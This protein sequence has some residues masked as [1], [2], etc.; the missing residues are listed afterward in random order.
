M[1]RGHRIDSDLS[2]T[3]SGVPDRFANRPSG[4]RYWFSRFRTNRWCPN[5]ITPLS[6]CQ[7]PFLPFS[8]APV[9]SQTKPSLFRSQIF[10]NKLNNHSAQAV[11]LAHKP[12]LALS[13]PGLP[14]ATAHWWRPG[15][16]VAFL[17]EASCPACI[18]AQH[19]FIF[20]F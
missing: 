3:E 7:V 9:R 4:R 1:W 14:V 17:P 11:D 6:S 10:G 20:W 19:I 18:E 8:I 16:G 12:L 15:G 13:V 2:P 5:A